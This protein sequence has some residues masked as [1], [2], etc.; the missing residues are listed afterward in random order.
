MTGFDCTFLEPAHSLAVPHFY[1]GNTTMSV[2]LYWTIYTACLVVG[3]S[4]ATMMVVS[5]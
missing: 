5:W 4:V 1:M 2:K 3:M